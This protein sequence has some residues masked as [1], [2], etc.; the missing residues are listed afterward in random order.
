MLG[1]CCVEVVVSETEVWC[2][3]CCVGVVVS[4]NEV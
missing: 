2:G 1:G 4:E 3:G